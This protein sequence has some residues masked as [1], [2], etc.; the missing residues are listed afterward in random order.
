M[1]TYVVIFKLAASPTQNRRE[2]MLHDRLVPGSWW[3]ETGSA[4]VVGDEAPLA[5]FCDRL[6][7]PGI[8][9]ER[10]DMAVV[11]DLDSGASQARGSFVDFGLFHL[12]PWI[13]KV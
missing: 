5:A 1:P 13:E 8:F 7:G 6:F 12:A 4:L 10:T 2:R 3:A 11:F 9:D